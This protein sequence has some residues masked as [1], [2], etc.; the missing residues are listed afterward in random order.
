MESRHG[1]V[2]FIELYHRTGSFFELHLPGVG[3]PLTAPYFTNSFGSCGKLFPPNESSQPLNP[4]TYHSDHLQVQENEIHP[5]SL[6][7]IYLQQTSRMFSVWSSQLTPFYSVLK[8]FLGSNP[9]KVSQCLRVGR[10][11][12][13]I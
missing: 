3:L 2:S 4:M 13:I 8:L 1:K 9:G 6:I 12:S 5:H 11:I 7:F 10:N